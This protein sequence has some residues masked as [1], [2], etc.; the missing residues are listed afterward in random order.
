MWF[1]CFNFDWQ[2][3]I[4]D[5]ARKGELGSVATLHPCYHD[6]SILGIKTQSLGMPP[7]PPQL[8]VLRETNG[9]AFS[10]HRPL[11]STNESNAETILRSEWK[12]KFD[13]LVVSS[14]ENVEHTAAVNRLAVSQ[15]QS[16]FA[17]ASQDGTCR[18]WELSQ[19]EDAVDLKSSLIYSGHFT[20][21]DSKV[22]V[23]DICII[24]NSHSVAS[25]AS[26]GSVHIWRVDM[27]CSKGGSALSGSHAQSSQTL[28]TGK[29]TELK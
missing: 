29:K 1:Y 27:T 20:P 11:L 12:P 3:K 18:V 26:N 10:W 6:A 5:A 28:K 7:L 22:R 13:S 23:N 25:V 21:E 17:S 14:S 4:F 24:E 8:G 2:L 16:F 19:M 15:D 9:K